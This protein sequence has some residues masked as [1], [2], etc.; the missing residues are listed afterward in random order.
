MA[1]IVLRTPQIPWMA[2]SIAAVAI[3]LA[4]TVTAI[5]R[6][7]PPDARAVTWARLPSLP[8]PVGVAG[9]FAGVAD[10]A[11]V[12]AGGANFPERPPWDGGSKVW[13]DQVWRL[14]PDAAEWIAA[15]RLP[16]PLA[17][18]VSVTEPRGV[19]CVGG[20]DAEGHSTSCFRMRVVEGR[21]TC[22]PLPDLPR[23]VA[24]ACGAVVGT[25]VYVCGGTEAP[26]AARA[27]ATLWS[28]D[29]A[30]DE[31]RWVGREECPGGG[32]LLA[33]AAATQSTLYVFGGADLESAAEGR[34]VRR[35][36]RDA[37]A[38]RADSGWTRCADM[39]TPI[40]AAPSPAPVIGSGEVVVL[41]GDTG[42]HVG[43][44]PPDRHP[45]FSRRL[46]AYDPAQDAWRHLGEAAAA[47]VTV[48]VV[49][50]QGR[51]VVPS[52]ESRPGVRSPEVWSVRLESE[53]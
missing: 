46:L 51:W 47:T 33:T 48:P 15:G 39:P 45:G 32:R 1:A 17:Y 21:V 24:N 28:L 31:G 34:V 23:P 10:G 3:L 18:G 6:D 35:Y 9:P 5:A 41:G 42:V 37:W 16:R 29:L 43:F 25:M 8:D 40:V 7:P 36:R 50:W 52:G 22:T 14:D 4:A 13:H 20:S 2:R 26:D 38:Y 30:D 11:L 12:V 27:L 44:E 53:P 19:V 49:S